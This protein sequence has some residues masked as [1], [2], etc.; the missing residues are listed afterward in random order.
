MTR[1]LS[2]HTFKPLTGDF[3]AL[4]GAGAGGERGWN[5]PAPLVS[6]SN[7]AE[8]LYPTRYEGISLEEDGQW[9]EGK[10]LWLRETAG[11]RNGK[12]RDVGTPEGGGPYLR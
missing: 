10:E 12:G 2:I 11:F 1:C 8:A 9:P 4:G 7:G 6:R 3:P 5:R